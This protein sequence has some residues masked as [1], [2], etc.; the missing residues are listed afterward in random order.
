MSVFD[1]FKQAWRQAVDNFW[2]ELE[3]DAARQPEGVYREVARARNQL[4]ELD[5]A[6]GA[7][8]Q[9]LREEKE[10]VQACVR[11]EG[12][13]RDIGDDETARIAAR[14]RDRHQ[15]RVDV[16]ERKA[17]ALE[18]E[19]RLC[20]RDLDEMEQALQSGRVGPA[21]PELDDLNRH[22]SEDEF[23]NLEDSDRSR[24]A[25]ERLEELKRRMKPDGA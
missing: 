1:E 24:T 20:A 16:L 9:R 22:P 11:R 13:A 19:R 17:D 12:M 23:R 7:T 3:A 2:Q 6:I 15:E 25:D 18:A 5:D 4:D 21:R 10:Q 8:R 14:Y